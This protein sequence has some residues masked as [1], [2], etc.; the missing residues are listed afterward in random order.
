VRNAAV[1]AAS[2][3]VLVALVALGA[4]MPA[5]ATAGPTAQPQMDSDQVDFDPPGPFGIEEL[6]TGGDQPQ[7][8]PPSVRYV[9]GSGS[10]A[11]AMS[12]QYRPA[13]PLENDPIFL[14][15]QGTTLNTDTIQLYSTVFGDEGTGEYEAV[16]VYW[17]EEQ[18][19]INGSTVSYAGDQEVQR[20][21]VDVEDGYARAPI[22]LNSHYNNT[23]EAT[24]WLEQDG[25]RVDGVR[26]RFEHASAATTQQVEINTQADAWWYA[27]RTAILPGVASIILGLSAARATLRRTGRGPG[28][29]LS[30]WAFVSGVGLL[31][32][33]AGLYYEISVVV[34]NLDILMGLS[35][36]PV[37]YGGGL[38]MSPPTEKIAFERKELSEALSLRRGES[39][40]DSEAVT[41][42]GESSMTDQITLDEDGY[43]DELYEDLV[44]LTTVRAPDGGRLL[45]ARG[46]RPFFARL[47]SSAAKLDLSDLRTRVRVNGSASQKVYVDPEGETAVDHKPA[48]LR[49]RMPVWHRLPETEDGESLTGLTRGLYGALTVGA[50]ALPYI[51]WRAGEALL[52]APTVG[53]LVGVVLL[54]VESYEAVDG[55]ISF[56]P[57]P[58][59]DITADASLTV[60]QS[61]HSDAKTLEE[62]EEIAWSERT[63]TALEA[64]EVD[65]RR[66]R[67]VARKFLESELNMDLGDTDVDENAGSETSGV[68]LE[69]EGR[70]DRRRQEADDD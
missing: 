22:E 8:A 68:P 12:I 61:E 51:G 54:A 39:E 40:P 38:R 35:L 23:H 57:A 3:A 21:T 60:M 36:L 24:M 9:G 52:N 20:V 58:R 10:V 43:F 63:R 44:L 30:V 34:A 59:H 48:H 47:F 55:S 2:L 28:Y 49:R 70:R 31:S 27:F 11:G 42:G 50:L 18:K 33:L 7:E 56:D 4:A 14:G 69:N 53:A 32:A 46:I 26:W 13:S 17:Q 45:P 6:R 16:I 29:S 66:D 15:E 5:Q 67:S 1:A 19:T 37:A 64:R 62:Y 65:T 25:D 41:D